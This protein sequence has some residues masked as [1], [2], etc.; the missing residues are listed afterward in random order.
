MT[1]SSTPPPCPSHLSHGS[2]FSAPAAREDAD[3]LPEIS[4]P[5]FNSSRVYNTFANRQR[6]AESTEA[7]AGVATAAGAGEEAGEGALSGDE[8]NVV[9]GRAA[10]PS[11]FLRPITTPRNET[12]PI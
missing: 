3:I 6:P 4:G 5:A 10:A 8:A 1:F 7:R 12:M 11:I 2:P 9:Q